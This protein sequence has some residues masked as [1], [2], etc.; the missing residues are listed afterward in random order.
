M[1][2]RDLLSVFAG[3]LK[4]AEPP[5]EPPIEVGVL[6]TP[7]KI[8]RVNFEIMAGVKIHQ[9]KEILRRGPSAAEAGRQAM[10][11]LYHK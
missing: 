3:A 2:F 7:H 1:K 8:R 6:V 5:S 4:R 10:H 9:D 11:D